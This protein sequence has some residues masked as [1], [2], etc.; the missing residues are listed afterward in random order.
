MSPQVGNFVQ[1]LVEMAKAMDELPGVKSELIYAKQAILERDEIVQAREVRILELKAELETKNEA[2]RALEVAKDQA[3]TMFLELDERVSKVLAMR[4]AIAD[5]VNNIFDMI[6]PPKPQPEPVNVPITEGIAPSNERNTELLADWAQDK[7]ETS[8]MPQGQ[9]ESPSMN[10]GLG[11]SQDKLDGLSQGQ[12]DL[13]PTSA[14][15]TGSQSA[16]VPST[17]ESVVGAEAEAVNGPYFGK[18]HFDTPNYVP[19]GE[20]IEGG[21]T[22]AGYWQRRE[23]QVK[24]G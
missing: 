1:D 5:M 13:D 7:V 9:S 21:G 23:D 15:T 11:T 14:S 19:Y 17:A 8:I 10:D 2:I 24:Y 6:D 20:W 4:P 18:N 3:E 12:S 16:S 22:H